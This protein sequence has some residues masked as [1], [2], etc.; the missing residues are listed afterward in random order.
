MLSPY[1]GSPKT[2]RPT[3][4]GKQKRKDQL[5]RHAEHDDQNDREPVF[6]HKAPDTEVRRQQSNFEP[7]EGKRV[8]RS[9]GILDLSRSDAI[10]ME[11]AQWLHTLLKVMTFCGGKYSMLNPRPHRVS[12]TLLVPANSGVHTGKD[13]KEEEKRRTHEQ[14]QS[15]HTPM[16]A[17]P[18]TG[19][20]SRPPT[21]AA[22]CATA[23]RNAS[24]QPRKPL[25]KTPARCRLRGQSDHADHGAGGCEPKSWR[26][27]RH[28]AGESRH[29]MI[30]KMPCRQDRPMIVI[31][32]QRT[33]GTAH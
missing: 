10:S 7:E 29:G 32:I 5:V 12:S 27:P 23:H 25:W 21:A 8:H 6:A 17:Q 30:F 1:S 31:N 19:P 4:K 18:S 2:H 20:H 15:L 22:E 16:P 26:G 14:P 3:G 11:R 13:G 9:A 33:A 24:R 28:W